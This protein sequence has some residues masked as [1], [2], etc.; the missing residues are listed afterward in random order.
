MPRPKKLT[1]EEIE[2]QK[3]LEMDM[4]MATQ[5]AKLKAAQEREQA[6][7]NQFQFQRSKLNHFWIIAKKKLEEKKAQLRYKEREIQVRLR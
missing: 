4:E 6:L 1:P 7:Y 5:C 3:Q 2:K